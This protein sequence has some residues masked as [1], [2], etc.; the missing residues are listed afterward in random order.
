MFFVNRR[1]K[2]W[3][4]YNRESLQVPYVCFVYSV[5][6]VVIQ[7]MFQPKYKWRIFKIVICLFVS[8]GIQRM[9]INMIE[10]TRLSM[11]KS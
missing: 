1:R 6:L 4:G 7:T 8:Y 11:E 3:L 9:E 2:E 5:H 10:C